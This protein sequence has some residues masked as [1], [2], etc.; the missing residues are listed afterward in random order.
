MMMDNDYGHAQPQ[1][2]E[3]PML[4]WYW[5]PHYI[6]YDTKVFAIVYLLRD[7]HL[8]LMDFLLETISM[9]S[10]Y[11]S[12][13]NGFYQ[14][15]G[16]NQFLNAVS[17]N[18]K[19]IAKLETWIRLRALSLVVE[20]VQR[21]MDQLKEFLTMKMT[22]ITPM[23]LMDFDLDCDITTILE[24]YSPWMHHI[25]LAAAQTPCAI[26]ENIKTVGLVSKSIYD[27]QA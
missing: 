22:D 8:T 7:M 26:R 2:I 27:T 12:T 17:Q 15:S 20:E 4:G 11:D 19:G 5:D 9:S 24:E 3:A 14:G 25:L 23:F 1:P 10:V 16:L 21:E 13:C 6:S 18:K